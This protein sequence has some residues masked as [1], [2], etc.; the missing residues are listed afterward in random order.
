MLEKIIDGIEVIVFCAFPIIVFVLATI[1]MLQ[2][3]GVI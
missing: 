2:I 1:R 3:Y